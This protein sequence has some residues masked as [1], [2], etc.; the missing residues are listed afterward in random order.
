MKQQKQSGAH[1]RKLREKRTKATASSQVF[2]TAFLKGSNPSASSGIPENQQNESVVSENLSDKSA[3]S[4]NQENESSL[5]QFDQSIINE[6]HDNLEQLNPDEV[7][8]F[9]ENTAIGNKSIEDVSSAPIP[10]KKDD[11]VLALIGDGSI[12]RSALQDMGAWPI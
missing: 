3:V 5:L 10:T 6:E 4:Q 8:Q 11:E 12:D 1:F 2:M 9:S 7:L